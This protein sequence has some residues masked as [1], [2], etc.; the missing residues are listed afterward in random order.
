MLTRDAVVKASL[1][2]GQEAGEE[3]L[4]M[5]ALAA[6]LGVSATSLY[7]IFDG[8]E[9]ILRELRAGAWNGLADALTPAL[10]ITRRRDRLRRMCEAYL[11]FARNNRWLYSLAMEGPLFEEELTDDQQARALGPVK[12][13][14]SA[15]SE[16]TGMGAGDGTAKLQVI[17]MW[18]SLHGIASLSASGQLGAAEQPT[19]VSAAD[20][21]AAYVDTLVD[22]V[23][24]EPSLHVV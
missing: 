24:L 4:T 14:L 16:G 19:G 2:L 22:S 6:R 12:V 21:H 9:A 13:A 17:E 23:A 11:E 20:F 10:Q 5:R 8:K 18:A 3:A 15:L 7:G 1:E